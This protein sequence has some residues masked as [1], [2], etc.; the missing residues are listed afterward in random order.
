MLKKLFRKFIFPIAYAFAW[1]L[2][3][4]YQMT[5]RVEHQGPFLEYLNRPEPVLL[6]W[7]H[8]DMLFNFVF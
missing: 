3:K 4:L 2:V 8:Q 6:T 5:C 7:W 1:M